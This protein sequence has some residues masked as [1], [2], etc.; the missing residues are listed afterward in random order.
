MT[1]MNFDYLNR[2]TGNSLLGYYLMYLLH[3]NTPFYSLS[4]NSWNVSIEFRMMVGPSLNWALQQNES[5]KR[6]AG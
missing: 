5:E 1:Q 2:D 6:R 3:S 4:R